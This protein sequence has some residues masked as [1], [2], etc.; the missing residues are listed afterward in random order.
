MA[1]FAI[2]SVGACS[3]RVF[4][5]EILLQSL[6]I[7]GADRKLLADIEE[8]KDKIG[9]YY[10][11]IQ[12]ILEEEKNCLC[13]ISELIRKLKT[14]S[15][16]IDELVQNSAPFESV[17]LKQENKPHIL[18]IYFVVDTSAS[19]GVALRTVNS[20]IEEL[21]PELKDISEGT[22][23][24]IRINIL[25][26][27]LSSKWT[28]D[29]AISVSE[30][31]WNGLTT[32]G[33]A[34]LGEAFKELDKRLGNYDYDDGEYFRPII[35]FITKANP[36]NDY[37]Y[38]LN[39]LK[40][41]PAFLKAKKIAIPVGE[42]VDEE[43][44]KNF[45]MDDNK[46]LV[47]HSPDE[48]KKQ[49]NFESFTNTLKG[50][51]RDREFDKQYDEMTAIRARQNFFEMIKMDD[52]SYS[53]LQNL[54]E[55]DLNKEEYGDIQ[56]NKE[57]GY[58]LYDDIS[59][60]L[61]PQIKP[62]IFMIDVSTSMQKY[63]DDITSSFRK[64]KT[65]LCDIGEHLRASI[66]IKTMVFNDEAEWIDKDFTCVEDYEFKEIQTSGEAKIGNAFQLLNQIMYHEILMKDRMTIHLPMV[67]LITDKNISDKCKKELEVLKNNTFFD[68]HCQRVVVGLG[69]NFD[70]LCY[71][72]FVPRK[73]NIIS[74]FS[75]DAIKEFILFNYDIKE[76][77]F[78]WKEDL[79]G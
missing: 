30:F 76:D 67:F 50:Y 57:A 66:E 78:F 63:I 23:N 1:K 60:L 61:S 70:A 19:M 77:W 28:H 40:S 58:N 44:I 48:I 79:S 45:V 34:N 27:S 22:K 33:A 7:E 29:N 41:N 17:V 39:L 55:D 47:C 59:L 43:I 9:I 4:A 73:E 54:S 42:I 52:S 3:L 37:L 10:E 26:V 31:E 2:S 16:E 53:N 24:D 6:L 32:F 69:E 15:E 20:A 38:G 51:K 56:D 36:Y 8:I 11:D 49:I 14:S 65:D 5:D 25:A 46:I 71:Q 62:I 72:D 74:S 13:T 64:M 35:Y 75:F 12:D 18:D 68:R 21:I